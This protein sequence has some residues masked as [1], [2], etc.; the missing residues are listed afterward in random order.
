MNKELP[1]PSAVLWDMDGTLIDQTIAIVQC[2][3]DVIIGMGKERPDP[4]TIR[5][6]LGGPMASTMALFIA[7]DELEAASRR[8]RAHFPSVMYEGLI[9]FPEAKQLVKQFAKHGLKQAILTNKHG[10]T[11]RSISRYCELDIDM[12][13][14]IGNTDT[15]WHKPQTELT[16][17]VLNL[18]DSDPEN[19]CLI[20]DSPTD[21]ETAINSGLICY[22]IATGAHTIE[23]LIE[24][25]AAA[26]FQNTSE[27]QEAIKWPKNKEF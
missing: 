27:L 26:T 17:H 5:R 22:G 9:C 12:P 20:G 7:P 18:L 3:S 1:C 8:F 25:G 14:C 4:D 15:E 13:I 19:V 11:A 16:Q 24:A 10:E 6:S 23:E 21:V 2:Y